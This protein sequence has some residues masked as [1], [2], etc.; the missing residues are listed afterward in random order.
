MMVCGKRL[1]NSQ[2]S[3]FTPGISHV[4][5]FFLTQNFNSEKRKKGSENELFPGDEVK[6]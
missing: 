1:A 6:I 2:Y 3:S 5:P 4:V